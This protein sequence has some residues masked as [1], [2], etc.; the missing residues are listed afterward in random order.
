MTKSKIQLSKSEF[1][2]LQVYMSVSTDIHF[3]TRVN[4][5]KRIDTADEFE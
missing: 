4:T 1:Q 3:S 5:D 2:L